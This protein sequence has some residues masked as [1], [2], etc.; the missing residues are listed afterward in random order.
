MIVHKERT[1][2]GVVRGPWLFIARVV[3]IADIKLMIP[4]TVWDPN[5]DC[6]ESVEE[7]QLS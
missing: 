5:V 4:E 6:A 7:D 3:T 1:R 2:M